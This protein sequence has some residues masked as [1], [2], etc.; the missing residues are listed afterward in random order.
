MTE[1]NDTVLISY[2][3]A[4]TF[5]KE[6]LLRVGLDDFSS[7]H[8]AESLM[9]ASL[10]GVDSHGIMRLPT[11]LR[12][13]PQMKR[14]RPEVVEDRKATALID[15][16]NNV[17][18]SCAAQ[19]MCLAIEKAKTYGIGFV[20]VKNSSHFGAAGYYSAMAP[21]ENMIGFAFTNAF[22]RI[23]PW[24][25]KDSLLGINPWSYAF[26]SRGAFPILL[27]ISN[28][29]VS[30]GKIRMAALKGE[31]IPLTW[32]TDLS[33]EPTD[34]PLTA[35]NGLLRPIGDY[36]GY[37]ISFIMDILCGVLTGSGFSDIVKPIEND[38]QLVGHILGAVDIEA[39]MPL[40]EFYDRLDQLVD[41][42]KKTS[43]L[44]EDSCVYIPGEIEYLVSQE[45]M[46]NGI[47]I[48]KTLFNEL[49][50]MANDLE[51]PMLCCL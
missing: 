3:E 23:P 30:V 1:Q 32:A 31:K 17:G 11:Y 9:Q 24:G 39:F 22:P 33:G 43:R 40:E 50:S 25:G 35:L 46:K 48:P 14:E 45:R 44:K 16:H 12:L 15:G 13:Y 27:D 47:P 8:V 6:L 10:Q 38:K 20:G 36:K 42:M 7:H 18:F 21:K 4:K 26:P 19:A 49:N 28:T 34:D 29:V 37:G 5:C 51:G 2:T 41:K